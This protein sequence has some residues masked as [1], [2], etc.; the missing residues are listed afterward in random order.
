MT[1]ESSTR[2][3]TWFQTG[4]GIHG[5]G[6]RQRRTR[7]FKPCN[8]YCK[9]DRSSGEGGLRCTSSQLLLRHHRDMSCKTGKTASQV[10]RILPSDAAQRPS[11][12]QHTVQVTTGTHVDLNDGDQL[13]NLS[14]WCRWVFTGL[15]CWHLCECPAAVEGRRMVDT[16]SPTHARVD[17]IMAASYIPFDRATSI[18][19]RRAGSC[20]VCGRWHSH[21]S[22]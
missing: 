19:K 18:S 22:N 15:P 1:F 9:M 17:H 10:S 6:R 16:Y 14:T 2:G 20:Q 5:Q 4:C 12:V 11:G 13:G 8:A 7:A 3:R 21:G